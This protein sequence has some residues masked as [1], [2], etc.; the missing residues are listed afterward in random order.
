MECQYR[1]VLYKPGSHYLTNQMYWKNIRLLLQKIKHSWF[2]QSDRPE[3]AIS[4]SFDKC[5]ARNNGR[6]SDTVRSEMAIDRKKYVTSGHFVRS[7]N[8]CASISHG[9]RKYSKLRRSQGRSEVRKVVAMFQSSLDT[10]KPI[11]KINTWLVI[12]SCYDH[13]CLFRVMEV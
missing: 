13:D 5:R 9:L 2:T 7:N 11:C 4:D 10:H 8:S 1:Y 12:L 6:S 3:E